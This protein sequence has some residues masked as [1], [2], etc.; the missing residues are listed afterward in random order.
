MDGKAGARKA[1]A[2]QR[3][4]PN[5]ARARLTVD[6]VLDAS[7]RILREEGQAAFNTNWIAERAGI[8]IGTLYGYFADKQAILVAIARHI[9]ME[10]RAAIET[11]L[12]QDGADPIGAIVR[13]LFRRHATDPA[14]RR[15]AMAAHLAGGHGAEHGD[16]VDWFLSRAARHHGLG[17]LGRGRLTVVTQAVL[18]IARAMSEDLLS[19]S[20]LPVETWEAEA[21]LLVRRALAP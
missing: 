4:R 17:R 21:V 11:A 13:A 3:R 9:L 7:A 16:S 2:I 20:G 1:R 12:A 6:A 18:G 14:V 15:I 19:P 10:D 5:Q 8:S